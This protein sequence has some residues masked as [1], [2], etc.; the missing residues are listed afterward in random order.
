MKHKLPILPAMALGIVAA[1]AAGV[2]T[3]HPPGG[4]AASEAPAFAQDPNIPVAVAVPAV[5]ATPVPSAP[6]RTNLSAEPCAGELV[7]QATERL[8][9]CATVSA[10]INLHSGL[11][12]ESLVA[13]GVYLQGPRESRRVRLE[14]K[15][16]LGDKVC[17]LQ[18]VSDGNSLWIVQSSL[19]FSRLGRVDVARAL[20]LLQQSGHA[21]QVG[22]PALG[23]LPVL[24]NRV[25]HAFEFTHLRSDKLGEMPVL[26]AQGQWKPAM[27]GELMPLQRQAIQSGQPPDLTQLPPYVPNLIELYIGRDDLFPYQIDYVRAATPGKHGDDDQVLASLKFVDV[28]F[29]TAIEPGQFAYYPGERVPVDDTESFVQRMLLR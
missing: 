21:P 2:L 22:A 25:T 11:F 16:R 20:T 10:K 23:G 19:S 15:L 13:G 5:G 27:L 6:G 4:P 17:S 1:V 26:V 12:G 3:A 24:M 14:L 18:Q 7:A 8:G 9:S 28:H 29:D